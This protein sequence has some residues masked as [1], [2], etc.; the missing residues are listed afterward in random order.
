LPAPRIHWNKPASHP[1]RAEQKR[2]AQ[3]FRQTANVPITI[4]GNA[5]NNEA[6]IYGQ[7]VQH[8][9]NLTGKLTM[10]CGLRADK[11]DA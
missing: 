1:G 4:V 7:Y 9:R 10:N 11:V 2:A 6:R 3:D 8:E 5:P